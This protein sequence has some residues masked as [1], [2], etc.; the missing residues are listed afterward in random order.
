M[1]RYRLRYV[2]FNGWPQ[3][4]PSELD[5]REFDTTLYWNLFIAIFLVTPA[6]TIAAGLSA[7]GTLGIFVAVLA[8][9]GGVAAVYQKWVH[10]DWRSRQPTPVAAS[11]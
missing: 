7:E 1:A 11:D 3:E 2:F 9:V 10:S 5:L 4:P 6:A 8:L